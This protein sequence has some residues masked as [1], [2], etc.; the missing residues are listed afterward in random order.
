MC[1]QSIVDWQVQYVFTVVPNN[2]LTSLSKVV[3]T[4]VFAFFTETWPAC[5][6]AGIESSMSARK[7]KRN[8]EGGKR[9]K[10]TRREGREKED[11]KRRRSKI[12]E[13]SDINNTLGLEVQGQDAC[14]HPLLHSVNGKTSLGVTCPVRIL[15][16]SSFR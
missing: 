2:K 13:K 8:E 4:R 1:T 16:S 5:L 14:K 3:S 6:T 9:M 10:R 11:E 12:Q 15:A 7:R